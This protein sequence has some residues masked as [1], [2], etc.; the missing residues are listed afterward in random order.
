MGALDERGV[1]VLVAIIPA[2]VVREAMPRDGDDP[3]GGLGTTGEARLARDRLCKGLLGQLLGQ[4]RIRVNPS[5]EVGVDPWHRDVVP[6]AEGSLGRED[7]YD[8]VI[9][10]APHVRRHCRLL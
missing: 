5:E 10:A 1:P 7:G 9:V 6:G 2:V 8:R 4:G 3:G